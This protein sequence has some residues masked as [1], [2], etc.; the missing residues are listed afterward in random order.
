MSK[1]K[2]LDLAGLTAYDT[3]IKEWFKS[4]IT[5]IT[6][7]PIRALFVTVAEGPADNEIWYTSSN[8]DVVTPSGD[9]GVSIVSNEY[10]NGKG[11]ITFD[12]P[13]TSIGDEA[14]QYCHSLT[15]VTIP[16]SV[17]SIGGAAFAHCSSLPSITIP[18]SVTSIGNVVFY[19]CSS[20]TS[21]IIPNSVT[22]IGEDAFKQCSYLTSITFEG[23]TEEWHNITKGYNWNFEVPA[24]HIQCT[25][26]QVGL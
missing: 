21:V 19:R 20:L 17:M 2:Y 18:N 24:T 23:T 5:D 1:S 9:F 7:D 22:S 4:G 25:D 12:G 16:N 11:V 13:V 26:G 6:E 15:S 14:F 8:G 3:K 10:N